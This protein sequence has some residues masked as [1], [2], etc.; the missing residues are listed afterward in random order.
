[1]TAAID[2]NRQPYIIESMEWFKLKAALI[3]KYAPAQYPALQKLMGSI[4]VESETSATNLGFQEASESNTP[5]TVTK[6]L[7]IASASPKDE[8]E[9]YFTQTAMKAMS[10][11][12]VDL[13]IQIIDDNIKDA[14][15]RD[16]AF[17]QLAYGL[18]GQGKG[19]RAQKLANDKII[20]A[21]LR[22][23]I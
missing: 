21:G 13:A 18:N 22:K 12:N 1:E 6:M 17:Q 9:G 8:R 5:E 4:Q 20:N 10:M 15:T 3:Q 2:S 14:D 11:D 7:A 19:E 23:G 16:Q